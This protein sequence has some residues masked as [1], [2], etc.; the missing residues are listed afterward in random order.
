MFTP[1]FFVFLINSLDKVISH[2]WLTQPIS[3]SGAGGGGGV[4]GLEPSGAT[5]SC[6]V[7]SR[8]LETIKAKS[9][10]MNSRPSIVNDQSKIRQHEYPH[11]TKMAP[12]G[13]MGLGPALKKP[14]AMNVDV[15]HS[16]AI[17]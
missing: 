13:S 6:H 15:P 1:L 11:K 8:Q 12:T 4:G 5:G 17:M 3:S 7:L 9:D 10:N 14:M 2:G 16:K